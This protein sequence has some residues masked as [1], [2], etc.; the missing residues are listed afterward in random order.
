MLRNDEPDKKEV[1]KPIKEVD[2]NNSS[3][4]YGEM[5]RNN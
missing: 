3:D 1:Q 4:D 5:M 2:E